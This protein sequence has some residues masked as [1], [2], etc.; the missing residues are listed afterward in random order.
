[1]R[2]IR[3][4]GLQWFLLLVLSCFLYMPGI[5]ASAV[6][7]SW[8]LY[9]D[10]I[11]YMVTPRNEIIIK[12]ARAS[13][14]E[15]IIPSEIDGCSVTEIESFA[16]KDCTR[17]TNVVLPETIQK[18]GEFAFKDC[19][20]LEKLTIPDSVA[21]IGWGIAQGT[22]WL[23]QQENDF[24]IAGQ[25][26]LLAYGGSDAIVCV[27]DGV[28][29][30]GGYAFDSCDTVESV[31]LPSSLLSIDAFA[32][33]NCSNL[34][35][36][37]IPDGV[38]T[39]GE[40]AFHWCT[41]LR[42]IRLPESVKSVDGQAF[43]YCKSLESVQLSSSM[44][45]ISNTL[46]RGCSKLET[47]E[48]PDS[49]EVIYNYAF[50]DCTAL[51][52]VVIPESVTEIGS[53][54][55]DGCSALQKLSILNPQCRIYDTDQ[56]IEKTAVIYGMA[57]STAHI[58]TQKYERN[59]IPLDCKKGDMN[60]DGE[61]T[62]LD[63]YEVLL[64]YAKQGAGIAQSLTDIQRYAADYNEDG[65]IDTMNAYEILLA[66]AKRAVGYFVEDRYADPF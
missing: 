4:R 33:L 47:I 53:C 58:Y 46:F 23:E 39:I 60:R 50:Q 17:L 1:M 29:A 43:S 6:S 65:E 61:L 11:Y 30:I 32:F 22:P 34:K 42:E 35:H 5:S 62:T 3:Q 16:F 7:A 14:T 12:S 15:V 26:I 51:K 49:V 36:V 2:G 55:F 63:A 28:R 56:T 41:S 10:T 18:I 54:V 48:I 45:Q 57:E 27:P 31:T 20:R 37:K 21:Q 8:K 40:Y 9:Q 25:G 13:L 19:I 64:I 24:V 44:T 38:E 66:Y 59:F 52:K